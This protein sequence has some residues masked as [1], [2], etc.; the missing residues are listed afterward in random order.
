VLKISYIK[1]EIILLKTEEKHLLHL[2]KDGFSYF[3]EVN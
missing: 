1:K 3:W 2:E